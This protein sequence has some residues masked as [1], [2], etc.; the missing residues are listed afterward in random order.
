MLVSGQSCFLPGAQPSRAQHGRTAG[1]SSDTTPAN[2]NGK[3]RNEIIQTAAVVMLCLRGVSHSYFIEYIELKPGLLS[4]AGTPMKQRV[5]TERKER[6]RKLP[7]YLQW[8]KADYSSPPRQGLHHQQKSCPYLCSVD[9]SLFH[10]LIFTSIQ[11]SRIQL[12]YT[13][14][15][16][17]QQQL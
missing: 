14:I 8:R 2:K 10:Q 12:Y 7:V 6:K 1:R 9:F 4:G 15:V 17:L 16:A 11:F 3:K 5:Q 13:V